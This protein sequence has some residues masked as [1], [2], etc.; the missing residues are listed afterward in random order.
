MSLGPPHITSGGSAW[1][2]RRTDR[3]GSGKASLVP[4]LGKFLDN[5]ADTADTVDSADT[6]DAADAADTVDTV[7]ATARRTEPPRAPAGT[8]AVIRPTA[9]RLPR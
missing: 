2:V 3:D 5:A 1:S 8:G 6:A 9:D 4:G 7:D